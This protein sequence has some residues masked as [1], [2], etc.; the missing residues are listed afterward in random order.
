MADK[1]PSLT[2]KGVFALHQISTRAVI[3]RTVKIRHSE[4]WYEAW[5]L[6][7]RTLDKKV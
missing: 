1:P 2:L 5:S 4:L 6:E 3:R 7:C